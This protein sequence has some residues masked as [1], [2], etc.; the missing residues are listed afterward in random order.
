MSTRRPPLNPFFLKEYESEYEFFSSGEIL[1]IITD[2]LGSAS[3]SKGEAKG[4]FEKLPLVESLQRC[5]RR[6]AI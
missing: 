4:S 6:R 3:S 1:S 2:A 5:D